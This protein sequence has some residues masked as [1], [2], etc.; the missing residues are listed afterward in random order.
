MAAN[1]FYISTNP[2]V[3]AKLASEIR[4]TFNSVDDIKLGPALNECVYLKAVV[5]ETLRMSPS[6]PGILPR[7]VLAGGIT[8][9]GHLFPAGVELTV[10]IYAIHHKPKYYPR[11]HTHDPERWIESSVGHDK[12]EKALSAFNPFSYGTRQCIGKRLAYTELWIAIAR[13]VWLFDLYYVSGGMEDEFGDG[14]VEYKLVD[15]FAAARTGPVVR[16]QKRS[17]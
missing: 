10:P 14:V 5:E 16:F 1:F 15:H 12:V 8:V 3:Q 9:A 13:A 6:V 2:T 7:E 17:M 11:P 4:S